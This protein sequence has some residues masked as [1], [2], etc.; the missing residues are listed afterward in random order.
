[1]AENNSGPIEA[2][3]GIVSG[4]IG[5]TKQVIGLILSRSEL[6]EEGRAQVE[7]AS[8]QLDAARAEAEAEAARTKAKAQESRQKAASNSK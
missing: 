5:F 2:V 3:R 4:A 6:Q 8:H 1:M 7:K